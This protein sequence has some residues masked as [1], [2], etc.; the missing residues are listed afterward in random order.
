M[1]WVLSPTRRHSTPGAARPCTALHEHPRGDRGPVLPRRRPSGERSRL[2]LAIR[3]SRS[4]RPWMDW[5][6]KAAS[7]RRQGSGNFG[8]LA[9]RE[10]IRRSLTS[11]ALSVRF[12]P[13][14]GESRGATERNARGGESATEWRG[15]GTTPGSLFRRGARLCFFH[16]TNLT[17]APLP[18]LSFSEEC[19]P[20]GRTPKS[21][22]MRRSEGG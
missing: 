10:E 8:R 17:H 9:H 1:T 6:K 2:D 20:A 5:W 13:A 11:R 4:A 14:G 12:L 21:E 19:A 3:A 16:T 7:L 22:W 15:G 18:S